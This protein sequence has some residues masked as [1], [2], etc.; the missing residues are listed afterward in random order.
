MRKILI[1]IMSL[2]MLVSASAFVACAESGESAA[3]HTHGG[4]KATCTEKAKCDECGKEYGELDK[5]NHKSAEFV[6]VSKGDGTHK[7]AHKCCNAEVEANE[8]CSGGE[9]AC[10]EKAKCV[11]CGGEYGETGAHSGGTATCKERAICT[12]CGQ[13]Y[14][15]LNPQKH[16]SEEFAYVSNGNGTHN[17]VHKCCNAVVEK[18]IVC[19]G[20]KATCEEKAKCDDCGGEHGELGAH[21]GGT[22]TCQSKAK[23]K[24]CGEEY[25]EL[26]NHSY[27]VAKN[28]GENHW[29]ACEYCDEINEETLAKHSIA[30][31]ETT[32]NGEI[33]KCEC[34]ETVTT[35][36]ENVLANE[37]E[38]HTIASFGGV[39]YNVEEAYNPVVTVN[40]A[41]LAISVSSDNENVAVF[42]DGKIK[43]VKAGKA[44]ITVTYTLPSDRGEV[45]KTFEVNVIRPVVT[46][47]T[48]VNYFSAIDGW[49]AYLT[50]LFGS[51]AITEAKQTYKGENYVLTYADGKLCGTFTESK[52][53]T[54]C[55]LTVCTDTYGYEL[56]NVTAYT[57]VINTVDDLADMRLTAER[58]TVDGYFIMNA[59]VDLW[60]VDING[61]GNKCN[62]DGNDTFYPYNGG[63]KD[64]LTVVND[65]TRADAAAG[66]VGTFDGNG[67]TISG[68][69][70]GN[71]YG[72]FGTLCGKRTDNPIVIDYA[73]VK[74]V[75]FL[76]THIFWTSWTTGKM[77][78]EYAAY[79]QIENV[80][81]QFT[82]DGTNAATE[83]KNFSLFGSQDSPY[84]KMKNVILN[85]NKTFSTDTLASSSTAG[86]GMFV[87]AAN[88]NYYAGKGDTSA[89]GYMMQGSIEG[90]YVVAPKAEN[91]RVMP[92]VQHGNYT[93]NAS[94]AWELSGSMTIYAANDFAD[95]SEKATISL[96]EKSRNP[97]AAESGAHY[98]YHWKNA[99]R[100]DNLTDMVAAGN[101]NIGKWVVSDSG[102]V[103]KW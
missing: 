26:G 28:N 3:A 52:T 35:I 36:V 81:I 46:D 97:L 96:D 66:F 2:I 83:N 6:Y 93:K 11:K 16:A 27:T 34:G 33:G 99:Y 39:N 25:G 72:F 89:L 15:E 44:V 17:E 74:N 90:L 82:H 20:G 95:L 47:E 37:M 24:T 42:E 94:G 23:C 7:K 56:T 58:K 79:T 69:R 29:Y 61:N 48:A 65:N 55:S 9:A 51:D 57:K 43:A 50:E 68:F 91:G 13:E 60:S 12:D 71:S 14:G 88:T 32:E 31:W 30:G 84:V 62:V 54:V 64:M 70:A 49:H 59:D 8:A 92:L 40:G 41:A 102:V 85:Y 4:E 53:S 19:A 10:G 22:A 98:V 86:V 63:S 76:N 78:A 87:S 73:V 5:E 103:W 38:L 21:D 101:T 1:A 80:Y 77:F 75:A 67:H 18:D 45:K 100:Y